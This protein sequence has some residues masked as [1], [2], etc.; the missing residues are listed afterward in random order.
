MKT[1]LFILKF[2]GLMDG[3]QFLLKL[4][5][6]VDKII[7]FKYVGL[8]IK[9]IYWENCIIFYFKRNPKLLKQKR[10]FSHKFIIDDSGTGRKKRMGIKW[11][12]LYFSPFLYL[13]E[14]EIASRKIRELECSTKFVT[15]RA[16]PCTELG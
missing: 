6:K 3:D 14:Y 4:N 11:R 16:Y 7:I 5:D 8:E 15:A 12:H 2:P 1:L 13:P 10:K 9:K